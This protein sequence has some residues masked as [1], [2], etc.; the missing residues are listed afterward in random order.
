MP[1]F[2]A[3]RNFYVIF[4]ANWKIFESFFVVVEIF[5]AIFLLY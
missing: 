4:C 3:V 1:F 2:V 5:C